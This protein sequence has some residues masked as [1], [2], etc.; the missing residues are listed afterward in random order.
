[1]PAVQHLPLPTEVPVPRAADAIVPP[2]HDPLASRENA[3]PEAEIAAAL[4]RGEEAALA[5]AYR[6]WGSLVY[7][8]ALRALR[9]PQDAE[10]VTQQVFLA[11]W[12]GRTRYQQDRGPLGAWLVG[13]T[14]HTV[15]DSL[16]ARTRRA[17][18][19]RSAAA[20]H[21]DAVRRH[22]D[23]E[24]EEALNRVLLLRELGDLPAVQRRLLGLA[25]WG[26]LTQ[27]QIARETGL[28]LG[29]VKSHIRRGLHALRGAMEAPSVRKK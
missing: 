14:R 10:D 23:N 4:V 3:P 26:D 2:P 11:A 18:L 16:T 1:M 5:A 22:Q 17:D 20:Q 9:D 28:P 8:L 13:I 29:T 24:S 27:T 19:A 7:S 25:I 15:I 21:D 6:H 12:R